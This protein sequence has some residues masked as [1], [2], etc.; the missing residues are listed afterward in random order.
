MIASL[1]DAILA[2]VKRLDPAAQERAMRYIGNPIR[3]LGGC[4]VCGS[5]AGDAG[6][7]VGLFVPQDDAVPQFVGYR[8]CAKHARGRTR[9]NPEAVEA[10]IVIASSLRPHELVAYAT[11]AGA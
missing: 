4:L 7:A 8:F 10:L 2:T 3:V 5:P 11:G 9:R 6:G 1:L